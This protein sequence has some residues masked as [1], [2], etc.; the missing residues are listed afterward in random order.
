MGNSNQLKL[1]LN[2][3]DTHGEPP[4][5]MCGIGDKPSEDMCGIG[6]EPSTVFDD[7][8]SSFFDKD[9]SEAHLER[10]VTYDEKPLERGVTY[11]EKPLERGVAYDEKPLERG[12]AYDEKP[13][14]KIYPIN[15]RY[16]MEK[17]EQQKYENAPINAVSSLFSQ[18]I[19]CV[20]NMSDTELAAITE[21]V[22]GTP[23]KA[24]DL[25]FSMKLLRNKYYI[26]DDAKGEIWKREYV[27]AVTVKKLD[28]TLKV[29]TAYV[30]S[31]KVKGTEW[32]KEATGCFAKIPSK[33][34]E[35]E[36]Y[37]AIIQCCIENETVPNEII[38]PTAGWRNIQNVG[39]RFIYAG[40]IIGENNSLIH[41]AGNG[42]TLDVNTKEVYSQKNFFDAMGMMN[43]CKNSAASSELLLF[44]HASML[45]T[46][47]EEAG[48]PINFVF[49]IVGI[50]NSRKTSMATAV[51]QVFDRQKLKANAEIAT[52]TSCGIEK[53]LGTYKDGV[54]IVDDF[55]P[56]ANP[57]QTR[58]MVA[59]LDEFVRLTGNRVP[60]SRMTEFMQNP[61][62]KFFP[63]TSSCVCTMELVQ[64]V[65]STISRM[66]LTEIDAD[67][68][69]NICL[70]HYQTEKWILP[71]H[72]YA[73]LSWVTVNYEMV[74]DDI[75]KRFPELRSCQK[76]VF[77]RYTEMYATLMIAAEI[78]A[79]YACDRMF[80]NEAQRVDFLVKINQML[81]SD[82]H[83][84]E[85][86]ANQRDKTDVVKRA[87][88][89][90][91]LHGK[92]EMY[93]LTPENASLNAEAY[94]DDTKVY[95]RSQYVKNIVNNFCVANSEIFRVGD[96]AEIIDLLEKAELL[97]IAITKSRKERSRKLPFQKE[98]TLRY[99]HIKKSEIAKLFIE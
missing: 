30:P 2:F 7:D 27:I 69:D 95:A 14:E 45:S 64:G 49:G 23:V 82:L 88:Q 84:M 61:E 8:Q 25:N 66:F 50:T 44:V 92:I 71:T 81:I 90:A 56:G 17:P 86:K 65:T 75:K 96:I 43:I 98:N 51:A 40:G 59:K 97:D 34:E 9:H 80:W 57:S 29:F 21:C 20:K 72:I 53:I 60:K 70:A 13:V 91:F 15:T 18:M 35:K 83:L 79:K 89:D 87:L 48:F 62:K 6:G 67:S 4:K 42:N 19:S 85:E 38:Y 24:V 94:E 32:L 76:F 11:D 12:V 55:K 52:S 26:I 78:I 36:E 73:F 33:K 28:G 22:T 10:G 93:Q 99:L 5:D 46:L 3:R 58:D 16:I 31:H 37:E 63:I 47:Y 74:R 77:G 1:H 68:V 54:V 39:H 41:T